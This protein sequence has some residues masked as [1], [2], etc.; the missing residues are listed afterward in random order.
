VPQGTIFAY[1][2]LPDMIRVKAG[3]TVTWYNSP[4]EPAHTVTAKDGSF[5]SGRMIAG[6]SF[7]FQ[8]ASPGTYDF[9][10]RLHPVMK[11]VVV[12]E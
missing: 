3:A 2:F 4:S 7:S 10:C 8:F 6:N 11:G 9:E 5:D 12:V 1:T